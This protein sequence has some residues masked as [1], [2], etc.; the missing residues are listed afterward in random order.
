MCSLTTECVLLLNDAFQVAQLSRLCR[1]DASAL[2]QVCVHVCK[3]KE[4]EEEE[5]EEMSRLRV[6]DTSAFS[7]V[8]VCMEDLFP[9]RLYL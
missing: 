1:N 3:E 6:Y 2:S 9:R 8:Y 7:R 4:E 5:E